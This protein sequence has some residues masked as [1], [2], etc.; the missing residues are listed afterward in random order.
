MTY[1]VRTVP[2]VS[3][4]AQHQKHDSQSKNLVM[5]LCLSTPL[6]AVGK[7]PQYRILKYIAHR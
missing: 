3:S 7:E 5:H 6:V 2:C 1:V 4:G